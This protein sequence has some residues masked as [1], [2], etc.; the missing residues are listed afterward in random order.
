MKDL[1][2]DQEIIMM[3]RDGCEV[4]Q[5]AEKVGLGTGYVVRQIREY[6]RLNRKGIRKVIPAESRFE[7]QPDTWG[8]IYI[9]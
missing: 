6:R 1:T 4:R 3:H 9:S 7:S 2:P 8:F 5:L